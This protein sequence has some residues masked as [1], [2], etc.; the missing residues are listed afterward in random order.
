M[1]KGWRTKK[2]QIVILFLVGVLL[3][4]IALPDGSKKQTDEGE[5]LTGGE[6][7]GTS[8]QMTEQEYVAAMERN[9]ERVLA[10]MKGVGEVTVMI[11]LKESA[12]AVVK[13]IL[14]GASAV[15]VCSAVYQ[16][17]NAFI[18]EANRF[19][20]TWM[21]RKGFNSIAQFKG[22]LNTKDVKGIN[23]FERT[24]FLKYFGKKE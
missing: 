22:K 12:E 3:L 10:Q 21:T 16:N 13:A 23:T 24:Q 1:L 18:G 9:L 4:V 8:G 20:S 6:T 2:D 15:E 11:T 7:T 14:A 17:T 5:L 19:L